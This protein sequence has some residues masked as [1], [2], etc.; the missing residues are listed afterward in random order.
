MCG[1]WIVLIVFLMLLFS[2]S[3]SSQNAANKNKSESQGAYKVPVV[4]MVLNT[5][6]QKMDYL[7]VHYWDNFHFNDSTSLNKPLVAEQAFADFINLLSSV[8]LEKATIGLSVLMHKAGTDAKMLQF[9]QGLGE[10]YLYDPNSPV[11]NERFYCSLLE[12]Y[13]AS[14]LIDDDWKIRPGKQYELAQKNKVGTKALDFTYTLKNEAESNLYGVKSKFLLL[15]F[16]N[17]G[18]TD[19]KEQREKILA[20]SLLT[21]LQ[22]DGS[23]KVLSLYPD[24]DLSEWKKYYSELPDNWINGYDKQAKMKDEEVYDLKAIP[25]LYLLNDQKIV[26]LKD[27]RFEEIEAFLFNQ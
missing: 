25:S 10:K 27:A 24:Q 22:E 6:Q 14:T 15:F 21:K 13:L 4:P 12:P 8:P 16:H 11:R 7:M 2:C 17:P 19:C 18:C 5:P 20:S 26:L 9:F 23:L 1:K 3:S